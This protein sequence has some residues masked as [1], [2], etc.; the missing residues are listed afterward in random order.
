MRSYWVR[1]ALSLMAGVLRGDG[2]AC[3]ENA[4]QEPPSHSVTFSVLWPLPPKQTGNHRLSLR[5]TLLVCSG[6]AAHVWG[7]EWRMFLAPTVLTWG[8]SDTRQFL[9]HGVKSTIPSQEYRSPENWLP[10][11]EAHPTNLHPRAC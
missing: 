2:D 8:P 10:A 11:A 3:E 7:S 1:V 5:A 9:L 4:V 6:P